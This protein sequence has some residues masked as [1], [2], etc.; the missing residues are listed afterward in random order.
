MQCFK[1]LNVQNYVQLILW[2]KT[3]LKERE[4]NIQYY[5]SNNIIYQFTVKKNKLQIISHDSTYPQ[6][7]TQKKNLHI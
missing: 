6:P 5:I 7:P 2:K 4:L 3:Y 1:H